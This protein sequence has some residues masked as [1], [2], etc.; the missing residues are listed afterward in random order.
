[1]K[2]TKP[3]FYYPSFVLVVSVFLFINFEAASG[4]HPSTVSNSNFS[5]TTSDAI[6]KT[7]RGIATNN[8][9]K[10]MSETIL[11][12]LNNSSTSRIIIAP[13][14]QTN[15]GTPVSESNSINSSD[16]VSNNQNQKDVQM[17]N[18]PEPTSAN[19]NTNSPRVITMDPSQQ[20]SIAN[21]ARTVADNETI[22][23][24]FQNPTDVDIVKRLEKIETLIQEYTTR[25]NVN[26]NDTAKSIEEYNNQ[27]I[28]ELSKIKS[29]IGGSSVLPAV[30]DGVATPRDVNDT[31][32]SIE[33]YNN[34]IINELSKI[35]SS[36]G[37][38]SYSSLLSAIISGALA[39]GIVSAVA[40]IILL[41]IYSD[42][43]IK[44]SEMKLRRRNNSNYT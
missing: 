24:Q 11:P 25:N 36:I 39:A 44:L 10:L 22:L 40:V 7:V 27:I 16:I 37:G 31:A 1:V 14:N 13:N 33:E 35:K 12:V 26:V 9:D 18:E 6:D 29:S 30:I 42:N 38:S 28:N 43:G 19:G 41:R 21:N 32:K 4:Q 23:L 34:Q 15:G 8:I 5:S 17:Q 3:V 20:P 2:D